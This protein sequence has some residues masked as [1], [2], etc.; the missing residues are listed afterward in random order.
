MTS[1]IIK[2]SVG[3]VYSVWFVIHDKLYISLMF[4]KNN[5]NSVEINF[6]LP[7]RSW[8]YKE[9]CLRLQSSVAGLATVALRRCTGGGRHFRVSFEFVLSTDNYCFGC[10]KNISRLIKQHQLEAGP[11]SRKLQECL[12]IDS[13]EAAAS[14]SATVSI[15]ARGLSMNHSRAC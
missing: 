6:L 11:V 9:T 2:T 1:R 4:S 5:N 15:S 3:P 12:M 10:L 8:S 14:L 13:Y 7:L